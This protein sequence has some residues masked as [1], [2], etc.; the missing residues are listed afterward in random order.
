M[1]QQGDPLRVEQ[2]HAAVAAAHERVVHELDRGGIVLALGG[3]MGFVLVQ[4]I[5]GAVV[6][7]LDDN[8]VLQNL[9]GVDDVIELAR[10]LQAVFLQEQGQVVT[11]VLAAHLQ[12][13]PPGEHGRLGVGIPFVQDIALIVV[14]EGQDGL[15]GTGGRLQQR[16]AGVPDVTQDA[17]DG[18][19]EQ[20]L[21]GAG[22]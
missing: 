13:L 3:E 22:A 9:I 8:P 14:V 4:E 11:R 1:L 19:R 15:D 6:G 18:I 21:A 17:I 12:K 2:V 5:E 16:A 20:E 10:V 7:S